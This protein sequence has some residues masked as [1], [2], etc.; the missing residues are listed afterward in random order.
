MKAEIVRY[1]IVLTIASSVAILIT[2]A[3]RRALR[4]LFGAAASYAAWLL[5]PA[6]MV[7]VLLPTPHSWG[8]TLESPSRIDSASA[9]SHA[10]DRSLSSLLQTA[11]A[12]DWTSLGL[13][14]WCVGA[15][16]FLVYLAG[17][18]RAFVGSLGA[19]SGS[20]RVLR[21]ERSAGCPA[22]LGVLWPRIVLPAD[23]ESRYT[24]LERLLIFSHE[25]TH[26]GR[27]DA[28]WNALVALMRCVFWFNPLV[29]LAG[30]CIR[31][32]QEMACDAAVLDE[33]P[34]SRRAYATAMLK[35]QLADAELPVGCHWRSA[36]QLKER[37]QMV[38][39]SA[40]SR[41]RR[42][43]GNV[44]VALA[45]L[46]L[47]YAAWAAEPSPPAS[48]ADT[49]T[50]IEPQHELHGPHLQ[51][52]LP[53]HSPGPMTYNADS[54]AQSFI[55][56]SDGTLILQGHVRI[57][58]TIPVEHRNSAGQVITMDWQRRVIEA[59]RVVM[60]PRPDG[61]VM[62]DIENGSVQY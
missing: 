18:Q 56:G 47:G 58:A 42:V 33:H 6:A 29:H 60:T 61:G 23:F 25:R 44:F 4:L 54:V 30:I 28:V 9:L 31:V 51:M 41:G 50:G 1:L 13:V 12:T 62:L 8:V 38:S 34:T 59:E 11:S 26:L 10:L 39:K 2:L 48:T 19:L 21:A 57:E 14:A 46:M 36:H 40:P 22:L 17:L 15:G 45:S 16:L 52:R 7:A 49:A 3:M 37:L 35:T 55:G 53:A 5:V 27:G 32:D 43:C 24:R 20:R